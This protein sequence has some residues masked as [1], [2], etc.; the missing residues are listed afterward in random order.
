M[1]PL[2]ATHRLRSL[3]DYDPNSGVFRWRK[4]MSPNAS[5]GSIAGSLKDDG[6]RWIVVD[7]QGYYAHRLA[8]KY[9]FGTDPVGRLDHRNNDH[10][11]NAIL[12]LRPATHSQN[13]C[14][15]KVNAR[16]R[17][18]LK[19]AYKINRGGWISI[20]T[21]ENTRHYLGHFKTPEAAHAAYA[22]KSRQLHGDFSRLE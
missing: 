18:G 14:N 1:K 15:R 5:A 2:P 20:I 9:H 6:H 16:T 10:D 12:N 13:M 21:F 22:A 17:S 4:N 11:N 8:W 19:G 3:L 7:G